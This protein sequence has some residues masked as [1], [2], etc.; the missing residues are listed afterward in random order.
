MNNKAMTN[1]NSR[2]IH[3]QWSKYILENKNNIEHN[4]GGKN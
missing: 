4:K 2:R 3:C 1:K